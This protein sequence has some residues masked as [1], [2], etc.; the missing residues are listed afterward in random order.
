MVEG[1]AQFDLVAA[2]LRADT[3]DLRIFVEGLTTKLE[4]SFPG[5]CRV[6]RSGLLG[7]GSVRRIVVDLGG[8]RYELVHEGGVV[9]TRRASIVR[10]IALKS[11][12]LSLDDW[13]DALAAELVSEADRSERGRLALERLLHG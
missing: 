2:S 1:S 9:T 12:E 7:R 11:D 5:R 3:D 8:G 6:Q 10:G 13:I 4:E